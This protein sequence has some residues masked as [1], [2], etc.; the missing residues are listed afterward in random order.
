ME[1]YLNSKMQNYINKSLTDFFQQYPI[2]DEKM[3]QKYK[4]YLLIRSR[5]KFKTNNSDFLQVLDAD[6]SKG[7]TSKGLENRQKEQEEKP[8]S[9]RCFLRTRIA[10][11]FQ[12]LS[13][14]S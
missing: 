2:T 11:F 14:L 6:Q 3:V 5:Q 12:K 9:Q 13:R 4:N 10:D 8:N 7:I 1:E